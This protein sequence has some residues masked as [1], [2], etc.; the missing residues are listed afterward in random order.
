MMIVNHLI[1]ILVVRAWDQ[2]VCSPYGFKFEPY[3]C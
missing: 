3:G 2:E 1:G